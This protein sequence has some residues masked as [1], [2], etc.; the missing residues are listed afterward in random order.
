MLYRLYKPEDFAALYAIEELC[1]QPPFRFGRGYMRQLVLDPETATW[2]A[3]DNAAMAGFAIVEWG[4]GKQG[5]IAYIE[6][7]EVLPG[8]RGQGIGGQLL[9]RIEASARAAGVRVIWLHVDEENAAAIR[10][11]E[12]NGYRRQG[13]EE[14]YYP[15]GR[16]ALIYTKT[17][18]NQALNL[19]CAG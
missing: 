11:Y 1:F 6:T 5:P 15:R 3:E 19:E 14:N 9:G 17:I 16:A 7:L 13:R 8:R 12:A 18:E 4:E 2:I 10:L